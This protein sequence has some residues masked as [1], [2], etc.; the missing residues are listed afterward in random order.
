MKSAGSSPLRPS[1]SPGQAFFV[2]GSR[3]T[4]HGSPSYILHPTFYILHSVFYVLP[5][6]AKGFAVASV[7]CSA[8]LL[9]GCGYHLAGRGTL[10]PAHVK[11]IHIPYFEN[12]TP[13]FE[14][15]QR[16]TEHVQREFTVRAKMDLVNSWSEADAVL[17]GA[18]TRF[19]VTPT[20]FNEQTQANRYQVT[21]EVRASLLDNHS[22]ETLW[23]SPSFIFRSEYE[24]P[25]EITDY[26]NQ[27]LDAIEGIAESFAQT[28][29]ATIIQGF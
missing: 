1:A 4:V 26:Y 28:L 21:I 24:S 14:L 23:E 12:E 20:G 27:E 22:H 16:L 11:K 9:M 25:D 2:H 17:E 15:E 13:R 19:T 29:V 10:L 5:V 18:I 8:F 3:F 7:L 6:F